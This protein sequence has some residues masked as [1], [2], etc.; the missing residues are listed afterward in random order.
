M[1]A[2]QSWQELSE[3]GGWWA[4]LS[5]SL[6]LSFP[7]QGAERGFPDKTPSNSPAGKSASLP[8]DFKA[9]CIFFPFL[10]LLVPFPHH[11]SIQLLPFKVINNNEVPG[12]L[13]RLECNFCLF[14]V[15]FC[16]GWGKLPPC[17]DSETWR[18][19]P[20]R[21]SLSPLLV[22]LKPLTRGEVNLHSFNSFFLIASRVEEG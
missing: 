15:K 2:P 19:Y 1:P 8:A 5:S 3:P 7:S 9:Y 18:R 4:H 13:H 6:S 14:Q 22:F 16:L 10:C 21:G 20:D 11:Q 12:E 17:R